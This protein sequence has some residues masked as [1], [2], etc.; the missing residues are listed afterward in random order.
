MSGDASSTST[1]SWDT[2]KYLQ[3][4]P[5]ITWEMAGAVG[6]GWQRAL[7]PLLQNTFKIQKRDGNPVLLFGIKCVVHMLLSGK[8]LLQAENGASFV[9]IGQ[10]LGRDLI[11][12]GECSVCSGSQV[13]SVCN[14]AHS[15]SLSDRQCLPSRALACG[16][17]WLWLFHGQAPGFSLRIHPLCWPSCLLALGLL[18]LSPGPDSLQLGL[19]LPILWT[20]HSWG[21][22]GDSGKEG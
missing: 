8:T 5:N 15:M 4:L 3:T 18:L 10:M 16:R 19:S 1:S 6:R 17:C 21:G 20:F 22:G 11:Y 9:V 2:P 13:V 14:P 12:V 7:S